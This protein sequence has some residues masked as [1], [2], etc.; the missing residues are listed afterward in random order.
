MG[1]SFNHIAGMAR[2]DGAHRRTYQGA[3]EG[4]AG[5]AAGRGDR[6]GGGG[7]AGM[8]GGKRA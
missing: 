6:A 7:A 1:I 4:D 2:A 8:H 3:E 5:Y